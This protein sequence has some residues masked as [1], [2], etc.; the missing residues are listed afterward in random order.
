MQVFGRFYSMRV[1]LLLFFTVYAQAQDTNPPSRTFSEIESQ[2]RQLQ[3]ENRRIDALRNQNSKDIWTSADTVAATMIE[4]PL[5]LLFGT[6]KDYENLGQ[7]IDIAEMEFQSGHDALGAAKVIDA[8]KQS[9]QLAKHVKDTLD[10]TTNPAE[11]ALKS[12]LALAEAIKPLSDF[13]EAIGRGTVLQDMQVRINTKITELQTE[14]FAAPY[15][16]LG[17]APQDA[18]I[19]FDPSTL[20]PEA[21][22]GWLKNQE[23]MRAE[24][25]GQSDTELRLQELRRKAAQAQS[26]LNDAQQQ[27]DVQ[28]SQNRYRFPGNGDVT[29]PETSARSG[30]QSPGPSIYPQIT[31]SSQWQSPRNY[32]CARGPC[33][34]EQWQ[35]ENTSKTNQCSGAGCTGSQIA[36]NNGQTPAPTHQ[37]QKPPQPA[38]QGNPQLG[39][40]S[41]QA[42]PPSPSPQPPPASGGDDP[43]S[44]AWLCQQIASIVQHD[45]NSLA[46]CR[47]KDQLCIQMFQAAV[48]SDLKSFNSNHCDAKLLH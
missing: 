27:Y 14:Q 23:R 25:L 21:Y 48:Q 45:K 5:S 19:T 33:T 11:V 34:L 15:I 31:T 13:E 30:A 9:Y 38:C 22:A 7:T 28:T 46:A 29:A 24:T 17:R 3:D 18:V 41:P 2:I 8:V 39:G 32:R 10:G 1:F 40:Y 37:P 47:P 44:H 20:S 36:G 4:Q 42:C 43:L 35:Q 16:D 12:Y 6:R 26:D